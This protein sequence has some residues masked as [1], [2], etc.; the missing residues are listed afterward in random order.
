VRV[1]P[2]DAAS[3][4]VIITLAIAACALQTPDRAQARPH[5]RTE[6]ACP[7]R[8]LSGS[9]TPQSK[10]DGA[11]ASAPA[12][13]SARARVGRGRRLRP[14]RRLLGPARTCPLRL[15]AP[16]VWSAAIPLAPGRF[17]SA[18]ACPALWQ[19]TAVADYPGSQV[20]FD[21]LD[22]FVRAPV[23]IE[24]EAALAGSLACPTST[25]CTALDGTGHELTFDPLE[26]AAHKPI[27]I[28]ALQPEALA[29]P[30]A[31]QCTAVDDLQGEITFDPSTLRTSSPR[32]PWSQVGGGVLSAIACPEPT[33][34]TA[35]SPGQEVT[36]DPLTG[37]LSTRATLQSD[38]SL[39]A[40]ACP[41]V[42]QCTAVGADGLELT[43]DPLAPRRRRRARIAPAIMLTSVAC[44]A[45]WRCVAVGAGER[46][47]V[48]DP[49]RP[50]RRS[51]VTLGTASPGVA[52]TGLSCPSI[53]ECVAVDAT[54]RAFV[55]RTAANH[56]RS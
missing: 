7:L 52:L 38:G 4:A 43:F 13:R 23:T 9:I 37:A 24:P 32:P 35:V 16:L 17:L 33:Q 26:R 29:C 40:A 42:S 41:T 10:P 46:A 27:A 25:Q 31:S 19:C 54:G 53:G 44:P 15:S 36:F 2:R 11:A 55:G 47:V 3:A 28:D 12:R 5:P 51:L 49:Q 39:T 18:I 48:F 45:S 14:A 20:T 1:N 22:R 34:C 8:A 21:P 50:G 30:S 56:A 6:T